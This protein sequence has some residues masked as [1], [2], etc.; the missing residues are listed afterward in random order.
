MKKATR[1]EDQ[2]IQFCNSYRV[3]IR[4]IK[5]ERLTT[6]T[7]IKKYLYRTLNKENIFT[8]CFYMQSEDEEN[9][10]LKWYSILLDEM[11]K[12]QLILYRDLFDIVLTFCIALKIPV[13]SIYDDTPDSS[14]DSKPTLIKKLEEKGIFEI[15][16]EFGMPA[17]RNDKSGITYN[18]LLTMQ[19][20]PHD[21]Q[22]TR[23]V[24]NKIN[25][26]L[27]SSDEPHEEEY[28]F[29]YIVE[30]LDNEENQNELRSSADK[31]L[32]ALKKII[33]LFL[34]SLSETDRDN[35]LM[36]NDGTD[37]KSRRIRFEQLSYTIL[38]ESVAYEDKAS[39]LNKISTHIDYYPTQIISSA[40]SDHIKNPLNSFDTCDICKEAMV[41][42]FISII[43]IFLFYNLQFFSDIIT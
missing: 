31:R 27:T 28:P 8:Y 29:S 26:K 11:Q 14:H 19:P 4:K 21:L 30:W 7:D 6:E 41:R 13:E 40:A 15:Y 5:E 25:E 39:L 32:T 2:L 10:G 38:P 17:V 24:F 42:I 12:N 1:Y 34:L 18:D 3:K 37:W 20:T 16:S 23:T 9:S 33:R 36:S 22:G 35:F 43:C